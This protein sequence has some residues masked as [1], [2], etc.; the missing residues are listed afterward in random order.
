VTPRSFEGQRSFH[1]PT[2]LNFARLISAWMMIA[3]TC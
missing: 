1:I 2:Q 3:K